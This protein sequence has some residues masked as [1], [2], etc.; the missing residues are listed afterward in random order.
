MLLQLLQHPSNGFKILFSFV[1]D[2][3]EDVV[4]V[5]Y[6]KNVKLFCQDLIDISLERSGCVG[7]SKRHYLVLEMVIISPKGYFP[8]IAFSDPHPM[9]G[10]G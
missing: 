3:D 4:K 6:H 9:I 1:F 2:R 8:L 7:Q 5:H 10:I